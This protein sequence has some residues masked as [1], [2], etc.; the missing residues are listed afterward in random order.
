MNINIS[1]KNAILEE[2]NRTYVS[3]IL[4][5]YN[6]KKV[7]PIKK[8]KSLPTKKNALDA[9]FIIFFKGQFSSRLRN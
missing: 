6:N 3:K 2:L 7:K 1:N 4:C 8:T 9:L 5:Y